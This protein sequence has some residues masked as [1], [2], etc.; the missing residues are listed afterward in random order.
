MCLKSVLSKTFSG[1]HKKETGREF[2]IW[3]RFPD[4][5]MGQTFDIFQQS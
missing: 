3:E 5:G 4:L 1:V 2:D